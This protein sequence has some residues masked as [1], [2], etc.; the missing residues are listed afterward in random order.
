MLVNL[1]HTQV[2]CNRVVRALDWGEAGYVAYAAQNSIVISNAE[3][4][5]LFS[6]VWQTE[7]Q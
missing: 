5:S 6:H 7:H 3:V 2:G 4:C 1:V